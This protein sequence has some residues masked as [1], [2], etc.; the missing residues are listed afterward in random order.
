MK[1]N[2]TLAYIRVS[3]DKQTVENQRNEISRYAVEHKLTIDEFIE[4]TITTRRSAK[5]R[6]IFETID[7]LGDGDI[8]IVS[9]LSRLGR[10]TQEV[11][12][13]IEMILAKKSSIIFIKQNLKVSHDK[14]DITSKVMITL[15]SLFA[16]LER[17]LIS[18]RTKEALKGKKDLGHKQEFLPTKYDDYE[19][20]IYDLKENL[21]LGYA[22]ICKFLDKD[23]SKGFKAQSMRI[24]FIKRYYKD[25]N[26]QIYQKTKNWIKHKEK[27]AKNNLGSN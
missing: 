9:E 11:L 20:E 13:I 10:S 19:E 21:K 16:E 6:K 7:K 14:Q 15:F 4:I 27:K 2:K 5:D 8:L 12:K 24:W 17:D 26:L 23:G 3:S 18:Q 1:K 22:N 25:E